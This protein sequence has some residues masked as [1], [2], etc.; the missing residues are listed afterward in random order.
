MHISILIMIY[1]TNRNGVGHLLTTHR[2]VYLNKPK[3]HVLQYRREI[4]YEKHVT[5][6]YITSMTHGLLQCLVNIRNY[7][8][9]VS[10]E[11]CHFRPLSNITKTNVLLPPLNYHKLPNLIREMEVNTNFALNE[12]MICLPSSHW[13]VTSEK[14]KVH[15]GE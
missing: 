2:Q 14:Y 6:V 8:V 10:F 12:L 9:H 13:S 1:L 15:R 4:Q 3:G 5:A 11:T 7:T